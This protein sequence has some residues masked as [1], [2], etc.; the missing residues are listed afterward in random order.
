MSTGSGLFAFLGSGFARIFGQIVPIRV[1]TQRYKFGSAR[2]F[3]IL[4]SGNVRRSKTP[5]PKLP[6]PDHSLS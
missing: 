6:L 1:H 5:L 4:T 3:K 2:V